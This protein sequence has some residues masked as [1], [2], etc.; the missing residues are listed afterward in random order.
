MPRT[1]EEGFRDFLQKL[2][3][4]DRETLDAAS[5][6]A[7]IKTRLETYFTLKHY[8]RI[9]SFGNGTSV[10]GFSDVDY[11]AALAAAD[12]SQSSNASLT[13][14]RNNLDERF[15]FTGVRVNC[16]AIKIPFGVLGRG[17]TEVVIADYLGKINGHRVYDIPDCAGGWIR[18]SPDAHNEYVRA[19]D[20]RLN[21]KVKP[22]IR[23]IKAWKFHQCVPI[24]SFYLEIATAAYSTGEPSIVYATDVYRVLLAILNLQLQ[25]IKDPMGISQGGIVPCK[26]G[27]Q[28]FEAFSKLQTA[29]SRAER[30]I[31]A[32]DKGRISDAFDC[33]RLFY[34]NQFPTYYY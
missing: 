24:S 9:G 10:Y 19:A 28:H 16:P 33:W 20:Q 23:F 31:I 29:V 13:K 30:A 26:T 11:I 14:V 7:S 2:T 27:N 32:A 6:R 18:S 21:G 25:T 5:H 15:P 17:T 4:S 34:N 8:Y 3:A 1:V 12:L 22:L